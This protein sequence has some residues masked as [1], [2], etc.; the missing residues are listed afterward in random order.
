MTNFI[1]QQNFENS[2]ANFLKK[3]RKI[4]HKIEF[5]VGR[6]YAYSGIYSGQNLRQVHDREKKI[7]P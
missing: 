7:E 2:E 1:S 6:G 4:S 5:C 3:E